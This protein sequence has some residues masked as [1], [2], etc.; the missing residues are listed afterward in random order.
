MLRDHTLFSD[1]HV[2]HKHGS[3]HTRFK[4]TVKND[5]MPNSLTVK[6]KWPI[7]NNQPLFTA[8]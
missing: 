2:K 5:A 4:C 7:W 3:S 1:S 8:L 6:N